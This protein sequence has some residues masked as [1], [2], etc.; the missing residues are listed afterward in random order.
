MDQRKTG[1]RGE[2]SRRAFLQGSALAG[3][4][5]FLAACTGGAQS[6]SA[7]ASIAVPTPPPVSP[8][9]SAAPS[10]APKPIPTGPLE[11]PTGAADLH[12]VGKAAQAQTYAPGSSPPAR[13]L[14]N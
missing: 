1:V 5:A 7:P 8:S 9:P 14:K 3:F 11:P 13:H 4:G 10:P 2:I 6:P 12:P